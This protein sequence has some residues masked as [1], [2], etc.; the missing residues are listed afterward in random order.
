MM[1]RQGR[2]GLSERRVALAGAALAALTA[3][4]PLHAPMLAVMRAIE[5]GQWEL[6]E[7]GS[8][9]APHLMCLISA[10]QLIQLRHATASCTRYVVEDKPETATVNYNC[11]GAGSGRTTIS[12]DT[13]RQFRLQTQGIAQAAPFDLDYAGKRVGAC[14]TTSR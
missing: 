5:P 3:A 7:V 8:S 11:Q 6:R 10:D 1:I 9:A 12:I 13:P 4:A 2:M 14:Q